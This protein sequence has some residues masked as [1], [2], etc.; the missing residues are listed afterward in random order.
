MKGEMMET[1]ILYNGDNGISVFWESED[2][3]ILINR[4]HKETLWTV[5]INSFVPKKMIAHQSIKTVINKLNK[6]G[7]NC[8]ISSEKRFVMP[9]VKGRMKLIDNI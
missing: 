5:F 9:H 3:Q 1:K 2:Q 6:M 8:L 7:Y 4:V